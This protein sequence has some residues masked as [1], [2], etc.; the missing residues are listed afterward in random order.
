MKNVTVESLLVMVSP[1]IAVGWISEMIVPI[2][3]RDFVLMST[4][5]PTIM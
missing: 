4:P 2:T 5:G 1:V 3:Q